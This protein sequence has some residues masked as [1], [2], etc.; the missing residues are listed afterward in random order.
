MVN[1]GGT[2]GC[3]RENSV[4][5]V[6][7]TE[8]SGTHPNGAEYYI[9]ETFVVDLGIIT[10]H[11][12]KYIYQAAPVIYTR[13]FVNN[14]WSQWLDTAK[15]I[16]NATT[17]YAGTFEIPELG[18]GYNTELNALVEGGLVP[19]GKTVELWCNNDTPI[20]KA[21]RSGIEA[22]YSGADFYGYL[23][24]HRTSDGATVFLTARDY[25]KFDT[26]INRWS[27]INSVGW[28]NEWKRI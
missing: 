21:V 10:Q 25:N 20:G 23:E 6:H 7:N 2:G 11:A 13:T 26:Y 1:A 8:A 4:V 15:L 12:I 24:V 16:N 22:T 19:A 28:L 3:L 18:I 14:E 5:W 17:H 27:S 9:L